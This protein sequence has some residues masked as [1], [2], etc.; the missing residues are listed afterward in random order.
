MTLHKKIPF[1]RQLISYASAGFALLDAESQDEVRNFI[2]EQQDESG[3]FCDRAGFPDL[4]Y[5]LFGSFLSSA[6]G[7]FDTRPA[8]ADLNDQP[9]GSPRLP[10]SREKMLGNPWKRNPGWIFQEYSKDC[11]HPEAFYLR[12]R[13]YFPYLPVFHGFPGFGCIWTE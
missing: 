5:T 10:G 3:G 9:D 6:T 12:G 13:R 2:V 1:Y 11:N 8:T 4:Y 7:L